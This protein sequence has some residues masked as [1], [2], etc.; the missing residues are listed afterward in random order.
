MV[1]GIDFL[2]PNFTIS[3]NLELCSLF[4]KSDN[5]FTVWHPSFHTTSPLFTVWHPVFTPYFHCSHY[6]SQSSSQLCTVYHM[7]N[8]NLFFTHNQATPHQYLDHLNHLGCVNIVGYNAWEHSTHQRV[9]YRCLHSTLW[10]QLQIIIISQYQKYL[11]ITSQSGPSLI[12]VC[13]SN[14]ISVINIS[15]SIVWC[16]WCL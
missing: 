4:L 14:N 7:V 13:V 8:N 10:Y 11:T 12:F 16:G 2:L 3:K 9:A 1:A 6:L 15:G 5:M